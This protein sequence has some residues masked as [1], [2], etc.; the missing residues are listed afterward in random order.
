MAIGD[1]A[2][3]RSAPLDFVRSLTSLH[4]ASRSLYFIEDPKNNDH[5]LSRLHHT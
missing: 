1:V 2:R 3:A 5:I 4:L